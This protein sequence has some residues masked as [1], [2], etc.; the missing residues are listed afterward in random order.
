[1]NNLPSLPDTKSQV[2]RQEVSVHWWNL[3]RNS[4]DE[5]VT[6]P[7]TDPLTHWLT[8][9]RSFNNQSSLPDMKI[10]VARQD[11]SVNSQLSFWVM[12]LTSHLGFW[13][14]IQDLS[15]CNNLFDFAFSMTQ[16]Q[17]KKEIGL[18]WSKCFSSGNDCSSWWWHGSRKERRQSQDNMS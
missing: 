13:L 14:K 1:M 18:N 15:P 2:A 3:G 16:V 12:G 6:H 4:P 7:L 9:K 17:T 5:Y 11:A 10:G 8:H